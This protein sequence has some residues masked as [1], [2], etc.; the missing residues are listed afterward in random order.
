MILGSD[1]LDAK[2][3]NF[4]AVRFVLASSVIYTHTLWLLRGMDGH[5]DLSGFL[6]A[7][8]SVYAVDGFFFLS[9]LLVYSSL[10]RLGK[11]RT[12]LLARLARLWP[13]LALSV[14]GSAAGGLFLTSAAPSQ[15]FAG[16][17]PWFLF[18]NLSLAGAWYHLTGVQCGAAP[19]LING[20]LWTLP[21]EA[22]CY[23]LLALL[24]ATG[25]ARPEIMA[26][27]IIPAVLGGALVLDFA[28]VQNMVTSALGPG[29][30]YNLLML[31]RLGF[32]FVL[33]IAAYVFRDRIKLSWLILAGVFMVNL[34]AHRVGAGVHVR[35][36]FIGYAVICFGL[37]TARRGGVSG[38]WPDYSYGMYIYA[39]PIMMLLN[40]VVPVRSHLL[41]ALLN[42]L[43]TLPV[44]ALSWHLVE[45]PALD[46]F[47]RRREERAAGAISA[48]M[49]HP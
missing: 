14:V 18:G 2:R 24:G 35:A 19:C 38:N 30:L 33:G 26:R 45:K 20:S 23:L 42:L 47:R 7:P 32:A 48:A 6:G 36:V 11:V 22:R 12:F 46:A 49:L 34:L 16:D 28:V 43:A 9:G 41:L 10:L 4:T 31:D 3:N 21:W 40:A 29:V 37:L 5:D 44:A 1:L 8:V 13:A 39:F 17:T 27:F 25:L 15:Y